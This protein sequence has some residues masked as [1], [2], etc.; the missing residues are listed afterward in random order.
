M[1]SEDPTPMI[2]ALTTCEVL[3][4]APIKETPRIRKVE[5]ICVEKLCSGRIL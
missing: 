2:A 4:G 3:T 1:R 5:V